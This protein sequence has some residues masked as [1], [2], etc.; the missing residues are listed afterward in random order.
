M[1]GVAHVAIL[2]IYIEQIGIRLN[3]PWI[4]ARAKLLVWLAP[5]LGLLFCTVVGPIVGWV[6]QVQL[7]L[8]GAGEGWGADGERWE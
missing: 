3:D 1:V 6:L 7:F 4:A 5:V 8:A 2:M